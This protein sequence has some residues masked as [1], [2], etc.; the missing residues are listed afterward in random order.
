MAV[1]G[2]LSGKVNEIPDREKEVVIADKFVVT[3]HWLSPKER[4]MIGKACIAPGRKGVA[5][6]DRDKHARA[7][8]RRVVKGWRGLTI[9]TLTGP[10]KIAI[11]P[12][13]L[14]ELKKVQETNGGELPFNQADSELIYLNALPDK[15]ANRIKEVMDEWDEEDKAQDEDDLG[16]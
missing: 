12:D 13:A 14:T 15:Y 9:D 3:V 4:D 11:Y 1:G 8:T 2:F 6:V 10:L 5:E 7:Y 16:K